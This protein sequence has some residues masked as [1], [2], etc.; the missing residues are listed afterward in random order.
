[1]PEAIR[2]QMPCFNGTAAAARNAI[3][4]DFL[5]RNFQA[6][7]LSAIRLVVSE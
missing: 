1:M 7:L 3:T 6:L 4:E 5:Q 2:D